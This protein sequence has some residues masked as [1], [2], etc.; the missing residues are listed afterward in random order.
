MHIGGRL[1]PPVCACRQHRPQRAHSTQGALPRRGQYQGYMQR[2]G[3]PRDVANRQA[4]TRA[5]TDGSDTSEP[6][7]LGSEVG[8]AAEAGNAEAALL[9]PK[10]YKGDGGGGGP[11][12]NPLLGQLYIFGSAVLWGTSAPAM[13]YLFLQGEGNAP[14]PSVIAAVQ[15]TAAAICLVVLDSASKQSR[16]STIP[17]PAVPDHTEAREQTEAVAAASAP[18]VESSSSAWPINLFL[19]ATA[20]SVAFA[21]CEIGLWA[22][23]A[24]CS[25]ITG[26]ENTTT[27]RG[28]FLIRLSAMFTPILAALAGERFP[29]PVWLGCFAAFAGGLLISADNSSSQAVGGSFLN[30]SS[31]DLFII[32]AAFM[33]SVQTVSVGRH[34]PNF[35][36]T[37]LAK[38]QLATMSLLSALWL[39]FDALQV[40]QEGRELHR[41]W[42][43]G[44]NL[45]NWG[46]I[47]IPA[48]GPWSI[49][50]ALQAK[51]QS[52]VSSAVAMI[53]LASDPLW[54]T[55]FAGLVGANEQHLGP[56]G[57]V[58]ATGI[59]FASVIASV[60]R[61]K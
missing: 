38:F 3:G 8:T 15:T 7:V 10:E 50:T 11:N 21:G 31:G 35:A 39:A 59:L 48:I 47:L 9:Q 14:T 45:L 33:W 58:G 17:S 19:T 36:P 18:A 16:R 44:T 56:L 12:S 25:T 26:F 51:G 1:Q 49:G 55:L 24:N 60:G 43:G 52:Q 53:I 32:F 4:S 46:V 13:R 57:W 42:G 37:T 54:A 5:Q 34:A 6:L 27:S 61:K 28:T 41:L 22:F 40:L 29:I 2:L 30:L 23:I 20:S